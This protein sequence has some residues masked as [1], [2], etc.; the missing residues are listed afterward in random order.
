MRKTCFIIQKFGKARSDDRKRADDVMEVIREVLTDLEYETKRADE[1]AD[2]GDIVD[3]VLE[4]LYDSDLVIADLTGASPNVYYEL[5]VRHAFRK[6]AICLIDGEEPKQFDVDKMRCIETEKGINAGSHLNKKLKQFILAEEENQKHGRVSNPV[7]IF[8]RGRAIHEK[9]TPDQVDLIG[10]IKDLVS[11]LKADLQRLDDVSAT[12]RE[13]T[14]RPLS[15][16]EQVLVYMHSALQEARAG[17][18]VWFA[19]MTLA[20]G[21][22]HRYRQT[23]V[24][25]GG[26]KTIDQLIRQVS[27]ETPSFNDMIQQMWRKFEELLKTDSDPFLV[28]L[29][30]TPEVL[31]GKFLE[32]LSTRTS[33]ESLRQD[34]DKVAVEIAEGHKRIASGLAKPHRMRFVDNIPFQILVVEKGVPARR[35]CLVFHVGTANIGTDIVEKGELGFYTEVDEVVDMFVNHVESLWESADPKR[36]KAIP[37]VAGIAPS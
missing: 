22:P 32:G 20:V 2:T 30:P 10:T 36:Q 31:K 18:R 34:L 35:C 5:G 19:G 23:A 29:D 17:G 1:I 11:G 15:G 6:S 25:G 21:P 26:Y 13:Y 37:A 16:I 12:M 3:Q 8:L 33:Y 28:C 27:D 7:T 9:G 14:R 4:R 24:E